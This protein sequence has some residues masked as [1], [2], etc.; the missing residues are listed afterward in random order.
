MTCAHQSFRVL[1]KGVPF[2][3]AR[4]STIFC[5]IILT[6]RL[7]RAFEI[8]IRHTTY[9]L[10]TFRHR[11]PWHTPTTVA[12]S[13]F[14]T[15][16]ISFVLSF[17]LFVVFPQSIIYDDDMNRGKSGTLIRLSCDRFLKRWKLIKNGISHAPGQCHLF[18]LSSTTKNRIFCCGTNSPRRWHHQRLDNLA[19]SSSSRLWTCDTIHPVS[20]F[21]IELGVPY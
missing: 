1:G 13:R 12:R 8:L 20:L 7:T 10:K 9:K 5:R 16:L 3:R 21:F 4:N 6:S 11:R 14:R 18:W 17:V 15:F 2:A 19:H